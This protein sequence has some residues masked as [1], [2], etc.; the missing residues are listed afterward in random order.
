MYTFSN[1][2][3]YRL[4]E[5]F[6]VYFRIFIFHIFTSCSTFEINLGLIFIIFYF[7]F[8]ATQKKTLEVNVYHPLIKELQKRVLADK[9]DKT[10]IDL[11]RVMFETATLRSGFVVKDSADFAG[12]IERMLR[13]SMGVDLDAKVDLPEEEEPT[14]EVT[15][16]VSFQIMAIF[17]LNHQ[18]EPIFDLSEGRILPECGFLVNTCSKLWQN[19]FSISRQ[20]YR[21]SNVFSPSTKYS[22]HC[23]FFR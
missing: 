1:F 9:E 14:E 8:Y 16:E 17:K 22:C 5:Y 2:K 21:H 10:A 3:I 23:F 4:N 6:F 12:R 20:R 18:N 13:L 15:E 11:A 7:S 19:N